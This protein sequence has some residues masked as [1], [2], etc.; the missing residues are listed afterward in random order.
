MFI[1]HFTVNLM[2]TRDTLDQPVHM[3][4]Y[5]VITL[6]QLGP[7]KCHVSYRHT[8]IKVAHCNGDTMSWH[9]CLLN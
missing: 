5:I 3:Q 1:H 8:F 9:I 7:D 2:T 6:E 4:I